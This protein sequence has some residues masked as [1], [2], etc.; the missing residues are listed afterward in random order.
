[1]RE[2]S[3]KSLENIDLFSM[4]NRHIDD[5]DIALLFF[6][7]DCIQK[8]IKSWSLPSYQFSAFKYYFSAKKMIVLRNI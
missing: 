5:N 1:M 2:T 4:K 7:C 6:I 8:E 3:L